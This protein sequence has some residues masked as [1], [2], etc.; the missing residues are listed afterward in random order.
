MSARTVRLT[1]WET[2]RHYGNPFNASAIGPDG[3]PKC[4]EWIK[5]R[6][7]GDGISVT[8]DNWQGPFTPGTTLIVQVDDQ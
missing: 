1:S 2:T 8:I 5:A 4:E 7:Q 3:R 6:F